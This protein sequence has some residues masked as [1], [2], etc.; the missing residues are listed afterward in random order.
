MVVLNGNLIERISL[1]GIQMRSIISLT[2]VNMHNA[3]GEEQKMNT[4]RYI[5]TNNKMVTK[6]EV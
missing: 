1:W 6:N 5:K 4:N 3:K 2:H